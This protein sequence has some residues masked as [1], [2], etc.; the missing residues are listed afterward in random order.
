MP[1][2]IPEV[3]L[4]QERAAK[5]VGEAK[6]VEKGTSGRFMEYSHICGKTV[7]PLNESNAWTALAMPL[8]LSCARPLIGWL[9]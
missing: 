4:V 5:W 9:W 7:R 3:V 8:L 6:K 2:Y 1:E